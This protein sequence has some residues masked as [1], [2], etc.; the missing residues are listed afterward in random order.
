M[1]PLS[2]AWVGLVGVVSAALSFL[3]FLAHMRVGNTPLIVTPGPAVL[4]AL[5][6]ALLIWSGL[7]VRR[8]RADKETW[9]NALPARAP[10][11][12]AP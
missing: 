1:K 3:G 5:A 11:S 9:I 10:W 4:F 7:A 12:A 2:I 6:T 8:L